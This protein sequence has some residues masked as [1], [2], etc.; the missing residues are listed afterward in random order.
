ML[1]KPLGLMD[2]RRYRA[3]I[4]FSLGDAYGPT[5]HFDRHATIP[6]DDSVHYMLDVSDSGL[7]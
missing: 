6:V 7:Y 1:G 2:S 3:H 4:D 5:A